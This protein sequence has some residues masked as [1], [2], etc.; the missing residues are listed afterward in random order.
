MTS[1]SR[2][3]IWNQYVDLAIKH[4]SK[5]TVRELLNRALSKNRKPKKVK[6]L[7]KKWLEFE[8]KEGSE[9]KVKEIKKR[10]ADWVSRFME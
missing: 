5:D 8:V 4:C 2:T 10:A 9:E 3:D 1:H 7:F 6:F